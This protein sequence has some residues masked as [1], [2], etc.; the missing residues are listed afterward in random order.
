MDDNA[1]VPRF[2][3]TAVETALG[4]TPVVVV[5]G[6]RQVGKSTLVQMVAA[7]RGTR[8]LTMDDPPTLDLARDDPK[9]VVG[10][11]PEGLLAIDEA[12]RAPGVILPVKANVDAD[13]RPARF[14]LTGSADLLQVKGVGDSLAGRAETVEM[15]PFSQGELAQLNEPEDFVT[16]LLSGAAGDGFPALEPE[17]VLR[18][19]F[20][21]ACARSDTR[22]RKWLDDY[23]GR[24]ADHDARDL[25]DGGYADQLGAMLGYFAALGQAELV[26]AQLARHLDVAE[27]TV[28][29]YWRLAKTMRLVQEFRAWNR[30]P[31]RRLVQRPKVCLLD[32]GLSAAL[33]NFTTAGARTP[34]GREYYGS[35][36][37]QFVALEL[38]KQKP[39]SATPYTVY[40]FR[41]L[42][43]LEV[44]LLLETADGHLIAIEVKA[45]T[46]PVQKHWRNLATLKERLPE[47]QLTGVLLHTGDTTAH[48]HGW[49]H[50]LPVTSLWRHGA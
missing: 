21:E 30:A 43:G 7:R 48:I 35:L 4:D 27:S 46:T 50:I 15:M 17:T 10:Q 2:A 40:H 20:P 1:L 38:T 47:R 6:A 49:L 11:Y 32:T 22:S 39:W 5:Q 3:L 26:K 44:D 25:Q 45:T 29:A 12:Q 16:W 42:D 14:L 19:G 9:S 33:A 28:D 23:A 37:E 18:G 24:L 36:V 31:H 34:G 41:E 13:R 8:V